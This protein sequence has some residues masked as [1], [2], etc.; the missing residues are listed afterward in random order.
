VICYKKDKSTKSCET[1]YKYN[2]I[3]QCTASTALSIKHLHHTYNVH[4]PL[5]VA[6]LHIQCITK[7]TKVSVKKFAPCFDFFSTF[8]LTQATQTR[9][10]I[11][12]YAYC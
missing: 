2:D 12:I 5:S 10:K 7:N 11:N 6:V 9:N 3:I 8:I 4:T 1:Q